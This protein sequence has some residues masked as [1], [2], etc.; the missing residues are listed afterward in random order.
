[1]AKFNEILVGRYNR[2]LQKLFQVKGTAPVPVL[3]TEIQPQISLFSGEELRYLEGWDSFGFA[4]AFAAVIGQTSQLRLRNPSTSNIIAV[5]SGLSVSAGVDQEIDVA[6][7]RAQTLDLT[8]Q[9]S[10]ELENRGRINSS[11]IV[12]TQTA[13]APPGGVAIFQ[14]AQIRGATESE[15]PLI[16]YEG[17]NIVLPPGAA[18]DLNSTVANSVMLVNARWRER[19]LEESERT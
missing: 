8:P 13:V 19:F 4:F 18:V 11:V 5:V 17:E 2:L 14:R 6:Y 7:S 1:M 15:H 3:S 9:S 16:R 12:S 10:V